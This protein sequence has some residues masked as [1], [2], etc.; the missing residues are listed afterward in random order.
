MWGRPITRPLTG[1]FYIPSLF[2]LPQCLGRS[3]WLG[4]LE[5]LM[6]RIVNIFK[7]KLNLKTASSKLFR[8]VR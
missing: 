1:C 6:F 7:V 5:E 4:Y 2:F 3:G 8:F